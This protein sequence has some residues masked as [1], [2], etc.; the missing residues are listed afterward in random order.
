MTLKASISRGDLIAGFPQLPLDIC[1]Y[2]QAHNLKVVGSNPTP[3]TSLKKPPQRGG[4]L[5]KQHEKTARSLSA[6]SLHIPMFKRIS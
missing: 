1:R 4:F 6:F 3:A 5:F 2:D